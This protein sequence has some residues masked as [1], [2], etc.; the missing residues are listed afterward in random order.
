VDELHE[1]STPE[2]VQK[3]NTATG[4]RRQ[5]LIFEITTAGHDRHSI[6]RQHHEFSVKTLEGSIPSDAADSWFAYIATIDPG[7][8]W[9]DPAVWIKANPSLGVTVKIDDLRRQVDEAREMPAQ[10]NAIRR[11]RLNEW[12]EQVTRW[13]DLRVWDEG[14]PPASTD[15]RR[16]KSDLDDL[17]GKLCGRECYGGLDLARVNDLSAFVLLF[18]PTGARD[19]GALAEKVDMTSAR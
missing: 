7:D 8:E 11:L 19:L 13:L 12:T 6:C 16:V 17:G 4:A 1:H 5:P 18:P 15:W 10:Q 14:G 2:I 9:T 3:L